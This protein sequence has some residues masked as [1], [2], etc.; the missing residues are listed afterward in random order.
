MWYKFAKYIEA[1]KAGMELGSLPYDLFAVIKNS[2]KIHE[3]YGESSTRLPDQFSDNDLE[4]LR[5]NGY[6]LSDLD[7]QNNSEYQ[8]DKLRSVVTEGYNRLD[9]WK[10]PQAKAKFEVEQ[11]ATRYLASRTDIFRHPPIFRFEKSPM[12][13]QG[14]SDDTMSG[15][16]FR[17][18][19]RGLGYDNVI[20]INPDQF[21]D[22]QAFLRILA[23][24]LSHA[25]ENEKA[26][27]NLKDT[28]AN[29]SPLKTH[30]VDDNLSEKDKKKDFYKNSRS[31][32]SA[33]VP[34]AVAHLVD[35]LTFE[36]EKGNMTPDQ[37]VESLIDMKNENKW[38][39]TNALWNFLN[40]RA[41]VNNLTQYF[42]PQSKRLYMTMLYNAIYNTDFLQRLP[43]YINT[44]VE[45]D[46]RG[47]KSNGS[48]SSRNIPDMY[49]FEEDDVAQ[50]AA[51][52]ISESVQG[53]AMDI[54]EESSAE[55]KKRLDRDYQSWQE[56]IT[57]FL[58]QEEQRKT[59]GKPPRKQSNWVGEDPKNSLRGYYLESIVSTHKQI[60]ML[61]AKYKEAIQTKSPE[62]EKIKEQLREMLSIQKESSNISKPFIEDAF[63]RLN[64][65]VNKKCTEI[66]VTPITFR[67]AGQYP[68]ANYADGLLFFGE[69]TFIFVP[70]Q[71]QIVL[72][73]Q[74]L[75][76]HNTDYKL[77]ATLA[78]IFQRELSKKNK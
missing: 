66:G 32:I 39:G 25:L 73:P 1:A 67:F 75:S 10:K 40:N 44:M 52:Q 78:D 23:H 77:F 68:V 27:Y 3:Y 50:L 48:V 43:E 41:G 13:Q 33:N 46:L 63:L 16:F 29:D 19:M 31:E 59:I 18:D 51:V 35:A 15:G 58:A 21:D 65:F 28:Y 72:G 62:A 11:D 20:A 49:D 12:W 69:Q 26:A 53:I 6:I 36:V 22:S 47:T 37:A 61:S 2:A 9:A 70:E 7:T 4:S 8:K 45:H 74:F 54:S 42:S 5:N 60:A 24:E 57:D 71:H 38:D 64:R 30:I 56:S 17:K 14:Y 76:N 55:A 34:E